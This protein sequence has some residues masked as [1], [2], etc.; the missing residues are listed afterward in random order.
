MRNTY[1][2]FWGLDF[3]ITLLSAENLRSGNVWHWFMR[4]KEIPRAL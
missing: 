1:F 3:G 2:S 4:N